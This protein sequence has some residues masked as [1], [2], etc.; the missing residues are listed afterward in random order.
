MSLL[1]FPASR[2]RTITPAGLLGLVVD[3]ALHAFSIA[4][5][6]LSAAISFNTWDWKET[7][8]ASTGPAKSMCEN[9]RSSAVVSLAESAFTSWVERSFK[10][11]DDRSMIISCSRFFRPLNSL[12]A[13]SLAPS[14]INL[15]AKIHAPCSSCKFAPSVFGDLS[16][17]RF[18]RVV[19]ASIA[20]SAV[21][22]RPFSGDPYPLGVGFNGL[23]EG[24]LKDDTI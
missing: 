5:V 22:N 13:R 2:H 10:L 12:Q 8:K 4:E 15:P 19:R 18:R 16:P 9:V 23:L 11:F 17:F 3:R 1:N 14:A 7:S 21:A 24:F 6:F 20:H